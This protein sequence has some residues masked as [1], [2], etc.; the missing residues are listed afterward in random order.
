[1]SSREVDPPPATGETYI[2]L[3][4]LDAIDG[5]MEPSQARVAVDPCPNVGHCESASVSRATFS[6][7][8][9]VPRNAA[10]AASDPAAYANPYTIHMHMSVTSRAEH[11]PVQG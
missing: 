11:C 10:A 6:S 4:S 1:M 5:G 7:P 2:I 8:P 3:G 9:C